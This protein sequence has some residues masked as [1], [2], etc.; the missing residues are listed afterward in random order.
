MVLLTREPP[1]RFGDDDERDSPLK[2]H[3]S[4]LLFA[5]STQPPL[6]FGDDAE[7]LHSNQRMIKKPRFLMRGD[8][9]YVLRSWPT[10]RSQR[11]P[12]VDVAS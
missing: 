5:S 8:T 6:R 1:L 10:P 4:F 3:G 11:N 7:D 2:P 9:Q 12:P